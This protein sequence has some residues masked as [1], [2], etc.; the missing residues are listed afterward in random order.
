M[1]TKTPKPLYLTEI[2]HSVQ[3]ESSFC[4]LPTTFIRLSG[5]NLRCSWCD[6]SYSFSR[7][8]PWK[9]QEIVDQ[10]NSYQA[11]YICITGGEPLLQPQVYPLMDALIEN[12]NSLTLETGGGVSIEKVRP[13]VHTILDVKCPKSNMSD[14]NTWSN[15]ELLRSHD[16]VKFVIAD[17]TDYDYA[18]EIY[19]DFDLNKRVNNV[20]F[21][22]SF[23]ELD[24]KILCEW[25]LED[26]LQVRLNLQTHKFIW[27][28]TTQGV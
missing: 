6:T 18:V 10:V 24:A 11:H 4:G 1:I 25:I 15:L 9:I 17:R 14:R 28:P 19:K 16:E 3:G 7:G 2:F 21:S 13:E 22:P 20:L 8:V 26:H 5:C 27:C 23:E 12:G